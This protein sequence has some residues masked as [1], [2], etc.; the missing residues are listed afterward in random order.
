MSEA[1]ETLLEQIRACRTCAGDLPHPPRPVIRAA[2]SA[3]LCIV[4]Q[5]PGTRVHATGI[6]FNDRSGDVL[7]SWL[8]LSPDVFYD[9][10]RVAI[11]PMGF[12]FPGQDE[13]GGDRPPRREC[14]PLWR[15]RVFAHLPNLQLTVLV[16]LYAQAWHL[17][18]ARR[19]TLTE[20]V[21][22]WRDY[23]PA[24]FPLPHPSWRNRA[25]LAANPWFT[26]EVVPALQ[27]R[28]SAIVLS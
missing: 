13:K 25:W 16:G 2:D 19:K 22:R 14:A 18:T 23:G 8:G 21:L 5:A 27:A 17:G 6:P 9:E 24:L 10:S 4:G 12:C 28:V 15:P 1:L 20:T 7:R 26:Q 11:V 3:R